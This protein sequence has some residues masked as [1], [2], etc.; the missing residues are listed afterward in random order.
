MPEEIKRYR[1]FKGGLYRVLHEAT[2][3]ETEEELVIYQS[4]ADNR[5]WARPKAMFFAMV[6]TPEGQRPRFEEIVS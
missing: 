4:E 3:S 2:H 6:Q 1:H 5:I